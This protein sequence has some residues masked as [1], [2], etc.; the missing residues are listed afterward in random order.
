[1]S[2]LLQAFVDGFINPLTTPA[3]VLVLLALALLLARQPQRCAVLLVFALALAAGFVAIV[4]AVETTPARTMLLA[5]AVA[6]GVMI[7]A[8]WAPKLLAWLFAAIAGAAL[9]LD[10]PPQAVT[11]T[12][13]YATLG[14]TAV[15]ACAM[16]V[17]LA[18]GL[19]IGQQH[20]RLV[21]LAAFFA[22]LAAG[23]AAL[24]LAVATTSAANVVLAAAT[25]FA[26]LVALAYPVPPLVSVPLV[27]IAGIALGLDSPPEAISIAAAIA[28]LIGTGIGASLAV[29]VI[30][31]GTSWFTRPWQQIGVRILGSWIAASAILVLALR[32]VRGQLL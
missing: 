18:I 14:G 13:A 17:L 7:A 28:M 29:A 21:P 27:A 3:H 16:L 9:A 23:L 11:I 5:V 6:L 12:E 25:L 31:A 20:G 15:G 19:L 10:S 2:G 26:L 24:A 30:A 22:G 4:L 1:M 8:A 32:F